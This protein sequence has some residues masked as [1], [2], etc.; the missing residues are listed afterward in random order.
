MT[1]QSTDLRS[2][3]GRWLE[4]TGDC[5][6]LTEFMAERLR[7][8]VRAARAR[9]ERAQRETERLRA[10]L[11]ESPTEPTADIVAELE[12]ALTAVAR[13]HAAAAVATP[14]RLPGAEG[15]KVQ[16]E[17]R[18]D[19]AERAVQAPIERRRRLT[20]ALARAEQQLEAAH[21]DA[22]RVRDQMITH[23]LGGND[24]T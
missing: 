13:A 5:D 11:A 14:A 4:G 15:T 20:A 21:R 19:A 17:A 24:E 23:I 10:E 1:T 16:A 8:P 22:M 6:R 2:E 7:A 9:M 18:R 12:A 3:V